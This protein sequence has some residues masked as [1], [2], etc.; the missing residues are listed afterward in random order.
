MQRDRR[1]RDLETAVG[2]AALENIPDAD[3]ELYCDACLGPRAYRRRLDAA[4]A[5][6][7]AQGWDGISSWGSRVAE[8]PED[9]RARHGR[10]KAEAEE[11]VARFVC[12]GC[13]S[14]DGIDAAV[15]RA[16]REGC[17]E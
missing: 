14:Q 11:R 1:L 13:G 10:W 4:R 17:L 8:T 16:R 12:R 7:F 5:R 9:Q 2:R 3:V 15:L 6:L